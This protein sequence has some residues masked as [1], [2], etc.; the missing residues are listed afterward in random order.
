[1]KAT[2]EKHMHCSQ[3]NALLF[4]RTDYR[5]TRMLSANLPRKSWSPVGRRWCRSEGWAWAGGAPTRPCEGHTA[6]EHFWAG[7]RLP[8]PQ[9]QEL[10]RLK[11]E[12]WRSLLQNKS[13]LSPNNVK[14]KANKWKITFWQTK[15]NCLNRHLNYLIVTCFSDMIQFSFLKHVSVW[16]SSKN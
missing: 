9:Q 4:T 2:V 6:G 14:C 15:T 3:Y 12:K 1:M 13:F 8:F 5:Y 16:F 7:G 10:G 11:W